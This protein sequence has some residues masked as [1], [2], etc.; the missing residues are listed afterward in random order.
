MERIPSGIGLD[1]WTDG[2][3]LYGEITWEVQAG[4]PDFE[5]LEV[6]GFKAS[7]VQI[8]KNELLSKTRLAHGEISHKVNIAI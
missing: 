8:S 3:G 4:D 7:L 2:F 5:Q 1:E 6:G